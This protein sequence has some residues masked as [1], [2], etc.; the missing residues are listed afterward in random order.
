MSIRNLGDWSELDQDRDPVYAD[1][2]RVR[3]AQKGYQHISTTIDNTVTRLQKIVDANSDGLA[4]QYVSELQDSAGSIVD[5]LS[6]A[7]VRYRDVADQIARYEPDLDQGLAETAA[8]LNDARAAQTAQAKASAMPDPQ[9][10]PDGTTSFVEMQK[11]TAKSNVTDQA[12]SDLD[13]AKKRLNA[14]LDALNA[15][16]KRFGDAVN[17]NNYNDG[18]TDTFWDRLDAIFAEI[19]K[20]LGYIGIA[21]AALAFL[22]PGLNVLLL[23]GVVA[24]VAS[25]VVDSVLFA[26]GKGSLLDVVMDSVGL[27]LAGLGA[28]AS[29]IGAK[30]AK[31]AKSTAKL[32]AEFSGRT[33]KPQLEFTHITGEGH[34]IPA[35]AGGTAKDSM[36]IVTE[37]TFTADAA[38]LKN[39]ATEWEHMSDWFNNPATNWL[40]NKAGVVTPEIN[41][42]NSAKIQLKDAGEIWANLLKNPSKSGK[43]W[44]DAVGGLSGVRELEEV[45]GAIDGK[46]SPL[47]YVWGGTNTVLGL[48]QL[49]YS[50]GRTAHRIPD[51]NFGIGQS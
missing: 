34:L 5:R 24:G 31:A 3:A 6:K 8:A 18:L 44:L 15:A 20:Y 19:S 46:I 1:P 50:I 21:L 30:L 25:L 2:D 47:W 32:I 41:F 4:G 49:A 51:E 33:P 27:G 37:T 12:N 38:K 23:V 10:A 39:A 28:V 9:K 16:G 40:L 7:G 17:G 45:T 26:H 14:A 29:V 42:K 22:I 35:V 13:A 48:G 11:G 36:V 43:E